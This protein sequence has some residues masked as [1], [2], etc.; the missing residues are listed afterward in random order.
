MGCLLLSGCGGGGSGNSGTTVV[1]V[2]GGVTAQPNGAKGVTLNW[3]SVPATAGYNVYRSLSPNSILGSMTKVNSTPI[4]TGAVSYIDTGLNPSTTYY[5]KISSIAGGNDNASLEVSTTTKNV[6]PLIQMGGSIQGNPLTLVGTVSNITSGLNSATFVTT[7]GQF[8]YVSDQGSRSILKV[9][10]LT[11]ST[12]VLLGNNSC[13]AV[14]C[15][16]R[17]ITSD[18]AN[19]YVVDETPGEIKK[20]VISTGVS[21]TYIS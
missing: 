3:S 5:Y 18:G 13:T 8:I 17:G 21:S 19:L 10:P 16:P 12:T 1:S 14:L 9:N 15:S 6:K 4:S 11:G 20:I 2:P 7:D